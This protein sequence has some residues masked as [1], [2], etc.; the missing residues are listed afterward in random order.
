MGLKDSK[1]EKQENKLWPNTKGSGSLTQSLVM[2]FRET[3]WTF[4]KLVA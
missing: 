4:V 2:D 1:R 3:S